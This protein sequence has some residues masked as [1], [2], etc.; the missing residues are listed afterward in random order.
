MAEESKSAGVEG[1]AKADSAATAGK[2]E[3]KLTSDVRE[4]AVGPLNPSSPGDTGTTPGTNA[5]LG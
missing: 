2:G 5:P 4:K 3:T 1:T